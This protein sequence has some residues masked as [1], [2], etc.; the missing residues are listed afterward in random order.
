MAFLIAA[1]T[2]GFLGGFHCLGMCGPIA[3]ALPIGG[4]S[5][6]EKVFSILAYNFGRIITYSA[7]GVLFGLIGASF[8]LFGYQQKLSVVLGALILIGL[9]IP[10]QKLNT[11]AYSNGFFRVLQRVKN[12]IAMQ[13]QQRGIKSLFT[14]GL[15]NGLLPCGMVYMALAGAVAT[16]DVWKSVLFMAI[17]G[18]GTLPFMFTISYTSQL[19]SAKIKT[20]I[21]RLVPVMVGIMAVL[22]I[23]RGLNLGIRYISP[24]L[25]QDNAAT[26]TTKEQA[27]DCCHKR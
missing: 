27:L 3:M 2:L 26:C 6:T 7:F 11:W 1:L 15:L 23:L 12:K 19:L 10:Q 18:L 24:K 5:K 16:G 14:I 17:F 8:S 25:S 9:F 4:F 22:L 13:F 21:R 20:G